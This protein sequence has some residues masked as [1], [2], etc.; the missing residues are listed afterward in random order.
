[1]LW[2]WQYLLELN[3][4][5]TQTHKHTNTN[6]LPLWMM[7]SRNRLHAAGRL[8]SIWCSDCSAATA[9][10]ACW[11]PRAACATSVGSAEP[12][13]RISAGRCWCISCSSLPISTVARTEMNVSPDTTTSTSAFSRPVSRKQYS[14]SAVCDS[15]MFGTRVASVGSTERPSAA[16]KP[17]ASRQASW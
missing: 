16:T 10:H 15:Q 4:N 5:A 1:M 11:L 7:A 3:M 9:L 14:S 6:S 2:S 17:S 13:L 8:R 12:A